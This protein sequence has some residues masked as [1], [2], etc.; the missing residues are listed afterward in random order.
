M[1]TGAQLARRI[2]ATCTPRYAVVHSMN[3][4]GAASIAA[5]LRGAGWLVAVYP[6]AEWFRFIPSMLLRAWGID[7]VEC[8]VAR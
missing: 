7:P 2:V 5:V 4:A 3:A 8:V 6:A 1:T